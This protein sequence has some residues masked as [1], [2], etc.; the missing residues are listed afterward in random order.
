MVRWWWCCGA[1]WG[2]AR[3]GRRPF[4]CISHTP[5]C[6]P[7]A[8]LSRLCSGWASAISQAG[9][10]KGERELT[11]L[12]WGAFCWR[13]CVVAAVDPENLDVL[14]CRSVA[15]IHLSKVLRV[16]TDGCMWKAAE[17]G[18]K[19]AG[20][21]RR[22]YRAVCSPPLTHLSTS[23]RSLYA[24]LPSPTRSRCVCVHACMCVRACVRRRCSSRRYWRPWAHDRTCCLSARTRCTV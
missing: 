9:G 23:P 21:A 12:F 24:T 10:Q 1:S 20:V 15:L 18:G 6:A 17:G 11:G 22:G 3:T 13:A 2:H 14:R 5:A 16:R 4:A 19:V 7:R 8:G